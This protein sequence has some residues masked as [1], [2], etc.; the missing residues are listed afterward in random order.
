[1]KKIEAAHLG[2]FEKIIDIKG[3]N[4]MGGADYGYG[5]GFDNRKRLDFCIT[6]K[7]GYRYQILVGADD[8]IIV[9]A[10]EDIDCETCSVR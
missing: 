6:C 9:R 3:F 5:F 7:N 2:Y 4:C 10:C 1:M 8:R